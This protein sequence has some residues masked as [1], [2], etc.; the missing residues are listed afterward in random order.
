MPVID[1]NQLGVQKHHQNAHTPKA[2]TRKLYNS[3][4]P[5]PCIECSNCKKLFIPESFCRHSHVD[6][7]SKKQSH[8]G[9]D[10][11]NWPFYLHLDSDVTETRPDAPDCFINFVQTYRQHLENSGNS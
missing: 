10:S 6:L 4:S 1:L 9:F 8:W 5:D 11:S 7:S 2:R 3:L